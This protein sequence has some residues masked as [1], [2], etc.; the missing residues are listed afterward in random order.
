MNTISVN[1]D[2]NNLTKPYWK[3]WNHLTNPN[4]ILKA[5]SAVNSGQGLKSTRWKGC[6]SFWIIFLFLD[7]I[8]IKVVIWTK[9]F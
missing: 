4:V 2:K 7:K 1:N 6:F 3:G 8:F 5:D 9:L